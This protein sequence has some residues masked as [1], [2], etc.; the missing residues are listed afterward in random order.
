MKGEPMLGKRE[1]VA[2]L[3]R[4]GFPVDQAGRAFELILDTIGIG[5]RKGRTVY[6]RRICKIWTLTRPPRKWW[7]NWNQRYIYFGERQVL[8]IKPL[9]LKERNILAERRIKAKA[10]PTAA[11]PPPKKHNDSKSKPRNNNNEEEDD[12]NNNVY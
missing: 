3:M 10:K 9:L 1:I 11:K 4:E 8:K 7:D 6:F 5:L 12:D 2:V